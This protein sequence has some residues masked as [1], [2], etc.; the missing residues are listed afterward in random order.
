MVINAKIF[1]CIFKR[2][3]NKDFATLHFS[4]FIP[5]QKGLPDNSPD[6]CGWHGQRQKSP[7]G[8]NNRARKRVFLNE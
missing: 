8:K 2:Q 3:F 6:H 7:T 4:I 1:L 5:L